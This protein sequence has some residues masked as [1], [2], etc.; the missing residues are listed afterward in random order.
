[1]L[2]GGVAVVSLLQRGPRIRPG[3]RLLLFGDSLAVGLSPP[4]SQLAR[5]NGVIY[6]SLGKVGST[7][8]DWAGSTSLNR[9]L[10]QQLAQRPNVVLISLGTN[11]EFMSPQV[12]QAELPMMDALLELVRASGA[13]VGWVGPPKLP[14]AGNGIIRK[15]QAKI[16]KN[17]YFRSEDFEI[18]RAQDQLHPTVRG[19]CGWA[20][21]IWIWITGAPLSTS[22][23]CP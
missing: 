22:A 14:R 17:R 13:D 19:Y 20:G 16:P 12:A 5:D 23:T 3:D 11:D 4:L 18:P 15:I 2:A 7:I 9:D 6:S 8:R 1:M 10:R 21:Q